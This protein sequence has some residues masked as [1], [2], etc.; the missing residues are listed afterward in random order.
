MSRYDKFM[1]NI[2][3]ATKRK[4]NYTQITCYKVLASLVLVYGCENLAMKRSDGRKT[5]TAE[6]F[7]LRRVS[8]CSLID[9]VHNTIRR[10][11]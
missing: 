6:M 7:S 11:L 2:K 5:G 3:T 4:R 8:V 10:A 1:H 9:H